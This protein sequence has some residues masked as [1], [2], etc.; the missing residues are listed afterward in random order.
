MF[1]TKFIYILSS[2]WSKK[3]LRISWLKKIG[4]IWSYKSGI[5]I[6]HFLPSRNFKKAQMSTVLKACR[7]QCPIELSY[8]PR[9]NLLPARCHRQNKNFSL[10]KLISLQTVLSYFSMLQNWAEWKSFS[11]VFLF[12]MKKNQGNL[13]IALH[14]H[15]F[16]R[17]G[18]YSSNKPQKSSKHL[19]S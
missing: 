4:R 18:F 10:Q 19:K 1:F 12:S 5:N 7:V 11:K 17:V 6:F 3:K 2:V 16:R 15:F 9:W 14:W 13:K 8:N